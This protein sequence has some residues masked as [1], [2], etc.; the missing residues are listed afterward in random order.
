MSYSYVSAKYEVLTIGTQSFTFLSRK[1]AKA[2]HIV[3]SNFIEIRWT[4]TTTT[5]IPIGSPTNQRSE[6]KPTIIRPAF[7][8]VPIWAQFGPRT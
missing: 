2:E 3:P 8:H 1:I 6:M 5:T 7:G 4:K